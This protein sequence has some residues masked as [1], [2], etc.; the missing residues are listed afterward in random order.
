[1]LFCKFYYKTAAKPFGRYRHNL[2]VLA[3]TTGMTS[4]EM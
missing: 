3:R 4:L 2:I 1:M